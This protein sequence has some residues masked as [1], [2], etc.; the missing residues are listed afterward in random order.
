MNTKIYIL[1]A[2]FLYAGLSPAADD[3]ISNKRELAAIRQEIVKY[4][5]ELAQNQALENKTLD[6]LEALRREIDLT[7]G[8]I[9][10]LSKEILEREKQI[11]RHD[12]EI[13]RLNKELERL[14]ELLKKRIV[15]IY[16]HG[17]SIRAN[18]LLATH[19][20][21]QLQVW[22]RYQKMVVE[23]DQRNYHALIEKKQ[24]LEMHRDHLRMQIAERER[25]IRE[26]SQ[27]ESRL[28]ASRQKRKNI[29]VDV[30]DN[31][32]ILTQRLDQISKAEKEIS[33]LIIKAEENR[34]TE[35]ARK[36]KVQPNETRQQRRSHAFSSLKGK[37]IWPTKGKI[38]SQFGRQKHPN[39]NTVTENLGIEIQASPGSNVFAV[40]DGLVQTI[41]WQRGRGNIVIVSHDNGF[42]TVYTN[43][44]QILVE[45]QQSV[46]QGQP[47]GTVGEVGTLNGPVLHFQIWKNTQ[48]LNP[49]EW[50]S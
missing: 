16:K 48:N 7:T 18:A 49:E 42:Y 19:S 31:K 27:Q 15:S 33:S 17:R 50:L 6:F 5:K 1:F 26:K 25:K 35:Y 36:P 43:L 29:L 24:Q 14:K 23:N 40:D 45:S 30:K 3:S 41:T 10:T 20:W 38:V 46:K 8:Y 28:K 47:I 21:T 4:E 44:G 39:L 32:E 22:L 2:L 12:Q 34:L 9:R 13:G 11:A 37:L